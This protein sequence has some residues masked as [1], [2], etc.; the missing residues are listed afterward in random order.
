MDEYKKFKID[1]VRDYLKS[2][3]EKK[4]LTGTAFLD[5]YFV[6]HVEKGTR[7]EE[8]TDRHCLGLHKAFRADEIFDG[9]LE[10]LPTILYRFRINFNAPETLDKLADL[11]CNF[12][13]DGASS[14][15]VREL[16]KH[17]CAKF[18]LELV[19]MRLHAGFVPFMCN[20]QGFG[21][22]CLYRYQ[23]GMLDVLREYVHEILYSVILRNV[24]SDDE[25][26]ISFM[27]RETNVFN[28][29]TF[30][31]KTFADFRAT[32]LN[33]REDR[34]SVVQAY[35]DS[36]IERIKP[37]P[38][39]YVDLRK[40]GTESEKTRETIREPQEKRVED[41]SR[42][43]ERPQIKRRLFDDFADFAQTC[44]IY[45]ENDGSDRFIAVMGGGFERFCRI[46][47]RDGEVQ[48]SEYAFDDQ[49]PF[50]DGRIWRSPKDFYDDI[51]GNFGW[52]FEIATS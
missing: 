10:G 52:N 19:E 42:A 1:C 43:V 46:R 6:K 4:G 33:D 50:D 35:A 17:S 3:L 34:A 26:V 24:E 51:V 37:E 47:V 36:L 9:T 14:M 5:A 28:A 20:E 25:Y 8:L 41:N 31:A 38:G 29:F 30:G 49:Y 40:V 12:Y 15:G 27:N 23:N 2:E 7:S 21:Y 16:A 32:L 11:V 22:S 45:K 18:A 13:M 48:F 39:T 44:E